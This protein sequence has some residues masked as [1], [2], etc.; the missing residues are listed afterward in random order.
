MKFR[1]LVARSLFLVILAGVSPVGA[2]GPA[3]LSDPAE[4]IPVFHLTLD[5]APDDSSG[6]RPGIT[7][8]KIGL[9][10]GGGGAR[11]A[12]HV[13][14]LTVLEEMRVPVDYVVGTS[15]GSVVGGLYASGVSPEEI[16]RILA[17]IDWGDL[18]SDA[19]ARE[20]MPFRRKEEDREHLFAFEF[21][22]G[23]DGLRFPSGLVS[24]QKITHLLKTLTLGTTG[25]ES[26]DGLSLPFRSV[27]C[28]LKT[29]DMV[30]LSEGNLGDAIRA[31][32]SV[33]GAFSPVELDGRLLVDGGVVRNLPIDVARAMGADV[34]IAVDVSPGTSDQTCDSVLA[35]FKRNIAIMTA[36][37]VLAQTETLTE[38]DVLIVPKLGEIWSTDFTHA[39]DAIAIGEKEAREHTDRLSG[40]SVSGEAYDTYLR[41]LRRDTG[42]AVNELVI[43]DIRVTGAD[44]VSDHIIERVVKTK[45]GVPLDV[46][47]L[48]EDLGRIYEL[49]DFESVD[50]DIVKDGERRSLVID[51]K[52]KTWGPRFLRVGL[53]LNADFRG[54]NEYNLLAYLRT[55]RVNKLG[56]EW[57]TRASF[58]S[59]NELLTELYQPLDYGDFLFVNP[60]IRLE[61][62]DVEVSGE[63]GTRSEHRVGTEE[64][65][66][67]AGV[68][69]GTYGELRVGTFMGHVATDVRLG[70]PELDD[71]DQRTGGWTAR[72]TF[73]QIDNPSFPRSGGVLIV[74]G[75]FHRERFGSERS[76]H[77]V[78]AEARQAFTL[79]RNTFAAA[80]SAGSSLD[81]SMPVYDEFELGGFLSLSGFESGQLRGSHFCLFDLIYFNE[82]A[83]LPGPVGGG[84]YLGVSLEAGNVWHDLDDVAVG[85]A[86]FAGSVFIGA[87][88]VIGPFCVAFGWA[89]RGNASVY[90]SLGG[91]FG[92]G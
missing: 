81:S 82:I 41:Y 35:V 65:S 20:T 49:G 57:R 31:S 84:V 5:V 51:A 2:S 75:V 28:D 62:R 76:F 50:F 44:R 11:G 52:E 38:D 67:H 40:Y 42:T 58:G 61:R 69:F 13:G 92:P 59:V 15:I 26:F 56:A 9:V 24:G 47:V 71:D 78:Q 72:M 30:V 33:A 73:D 16:E 36:Q 80:W 64:A 34:V 66:L 12:A 86:Q 7:R 27:A 6:G 79:G 46:S 10:L 83:R 25:V 68:Q 55:A 37:N 1:K 90:L 18:F 60:Q 63:D 23:P 14:V 89:E 3:D 29:G 54:K 21:G 77:R 19:S 74:D 48:R 53:N 8:P 45:T 87:D 22:V 85:D 17:T 88:S 4:G 43:D 32:M 39:A 91:L 70:Q